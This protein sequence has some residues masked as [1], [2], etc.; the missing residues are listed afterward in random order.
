MLCSDCVLPLGTPCQSESVSD[1]LEVG[2]KDTAA[3]VADDCRPF[4]VLFC[5]LII[6]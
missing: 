4:L 6:V 2:N 3:H 1:A 5:F